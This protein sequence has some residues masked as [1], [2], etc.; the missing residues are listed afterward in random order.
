MVIVN[1]VVYVRDYLGGTE[2]ETAVA[3]AAFGAGSMV[4]AL[5]LPRF[6]DRFQDRP[7]MLTG[8][9][10]LSAGLLLG[11]FEPGFTGLLLIWVLL[12]SGSSLIQTPSG[13]LLKRSAS[14]GYRPAIYAAQFALSHACWLIA[15]ALA[16]WVGGLSSLMVAFLILGLVSLAS[17]IVAIRVWPVNDEV[18]KG[19]TH[20]AMQH[21]H[22]HTHDEHHQHVHEGWEGE[23]PHHHLHKHPSFTHRHA[24]FIDL[25]HS[26]W[27][28]K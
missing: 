27:P 18:E 4:V 7:F 26:H 25:H 9:G 24:Y 17:M 5:A 15:Y 3:F 19:H 28:D 8:G 6:L 23:Q 11:L 14:E 21:D 16:G 20:E 12:G 2:T 1:T 10:I 13:R 22:F